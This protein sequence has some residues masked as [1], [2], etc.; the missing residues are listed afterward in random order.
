M[1]TAEPGAAL[2]PDRVDLVDEDDRRG[3]LARGL[4]EVTHAARTDA[5]EH[6]H[7]VRSADGKEGDAGLAGNRTRE[8]RLA[9]A[10]GTDQQDAFRHASA[11]LLEAA[12][13]LEEVDDLADLLF[14]SLIA[15]HVFEG[16]TGAFG[17][18]DLGPGAP[19]RHDPG[20][21]PLGPPAHPDEEPDDQGDG[22][23]VEEELADHARA[24]RREGVLDV[25]CLELGVDR[26]GELGRRPRRRVARAVAERA[27]DGTGGVVEVGSLDL[28][29]REILLELREID[30]LGAGPVEHSRTDEQHDQ[31]DGD[32]GDRPAPDLFRA[33]GGARAGPSRSVAGAHVLRL[34][35]HADHRRRHRHKAGPRAGSGSGSRLAS[36]ERHGASVSF[37]LDR[38]GS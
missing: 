19:D 17:R 10:R 9:C 13:R 26:G 31:D 11:D 6:L 29:S 4:E 36:A 27:G 8:Q 34:T 12:G 38:N 28:M 7:E 18:V 14:D 35:T 2:A 37:G 32:A 3:L 1:P 5:D 24:G 23:Q 20:H 22:K 25:R 30:R 21:L 33:R 16:R 15:G